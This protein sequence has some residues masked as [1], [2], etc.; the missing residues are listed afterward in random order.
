MSRGIDKHA[1][2]YAETM[3]SHSAQHCIAWLE[4][5]I[6]EDQDVIDSLEENELYDFVEIFQR[7]IDRRQAL[8]ERLRLRRTECK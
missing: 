1:E 6:Q 4:A 5:K 7:D 2:M 8:I 3:D